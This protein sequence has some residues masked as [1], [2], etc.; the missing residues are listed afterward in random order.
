MSRKK[1]TKPTFKVG[2]WVRMSEHSQS[3]DCFN[4]FQGLGP[5]QITKMRYDSNYEDDPSPWYAVLRDAT[6]DDY[7]K[8]WEEH[9]ILDV[10][11]TAAQNAVERRPRG[12]SKANTAQV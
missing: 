8:F 6:V 2:Q 12:K 11:M 5:W 10:F 1:K 7:P 4:R 3:F 9:L